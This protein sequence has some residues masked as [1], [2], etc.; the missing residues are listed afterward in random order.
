MQACNLGE[1]SL[2][3]GGFAPLSRPI[4][5][6]NYS[7]LSEAPNL[8][9]SRAW[10][11]FIAEEQMHRLLQEGICIVCYTPADLSV[12][13]VVSLKEVLGIH[14]RSNNLFTYPLS[15]LQST[16]VRPMSPSTGHAIARTVYDSIRRNDQKLDRPL[17]VSTSPTSPADPT[18]TPQQ[19]LETFYAAQPGN[20]AP[21][22]TLSPREYDPVS[23]SLKW[24]APALEVLDRHRFLHLT[25]GVTPDGKRLAI[26]I[27]DDRGEMQEKELVALSSDQE[28][29]R[30]GKVWLYLQTHLRKS[31]VE[32]RVVITFLHSPSAATLECRLPILCK[33]S[34]QM[35]TLVNRLAHLS[36]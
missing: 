24:P 9:L 11:K 23:F 21:H 27:C 22:F 14:P 35:L 18:T 3:N 4:I 1:H 2:F 7:H 13:D 33:E 26:M 25:H 10:L 12:E 31:S 20:F 28:Q 32:W 17:S 5:G 36:P 19:M 6:A 34:S 15:Y 29:E 8:I 30:V 16:N